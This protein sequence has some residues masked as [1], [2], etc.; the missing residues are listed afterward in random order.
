MEPWGT[1][2]LAGNYCEDFPFRTTWSRLLLRKGEKTAK[3]LTSNS[4]R[5][6]FV[7]KTSFSNLVKS[8][9]YIKCCSS[10]SP[11]L[12][13]SPSKSI[14]YNCQK[15]VSMNGGQIQST[16]THSYHVLSVTFTAFFQVAKYH[17][18]FDVSYPK[19]CRDNYVKKSSHQSITKNSV[20]KILYK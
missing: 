4:T 8:L 7:K 11:R 12:V 16:F 10:S 9:G 6:K 20:N 1:P 13:K 3:Y 18:Y 17:Y 2:A 19:G 5:L 14:R 15:I